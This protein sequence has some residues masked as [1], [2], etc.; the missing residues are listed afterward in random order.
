MKLLTLI[1]LVSV[2]ALAQ[3]H[4]PTVEQCRA[5]YRLWTTNGTNFKDVSYKELLRRAEVMGQCAETDP[6]AMQVFA[7]DAMRLGW[8]KANV[9]YNDFSALLHETAGERVSKFLTRHHLMP[10]FIQ[11]DEAGKR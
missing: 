10:Q 1:V 2:V 8:K 4:A 5:D 6:A 11:E 9:N 3:E 7:E